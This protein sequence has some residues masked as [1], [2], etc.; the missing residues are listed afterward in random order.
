MMGKTVQK[1]KTIV[2]M[3]IPMMTKTWVRLKPQFLIMPVPMSHHFQ[4]SV[5][6]KKKGTHEA[7]SVTP[8]ARAYM[9]KNRMK[10]TRR[11]M[12]MVITI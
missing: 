10:V 2:A 1:N 6:Q 8:E 11:P 5:I 9:L 7:R 4:G 3:D 12:I